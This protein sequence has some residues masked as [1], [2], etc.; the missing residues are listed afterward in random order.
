LDK[1]KLLKR[2]TLSFVFPDEKKGEQI[3][4]HVPYGL[5]EILS[6]LTP[7]EL[8]HGKLVLSIPKGSTISD[9]VLPKLFLDDLVNRECR[10]R[11]SQLELFRLNH[12]DLKEKEDYEVQPVHRDGTWCRDYG[13]INNLFMLREPD[14][15]EEIVNDALDA[16]AELIGCDRSDMVL[17]EFLE[18]HVADSWDF[19]DSCIRE[20]CWKFQMSHRCDMVALHALQRFMSLGQGNASLVARIGLEEKLLELVPS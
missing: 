6:K 20:D 2:K 12:P 1:S 9:E 4:E 7:E 19:L 16:E 10:L 13:D 11:L 17:V 8:A 15:L 14:R 3:E 5:S 18:E